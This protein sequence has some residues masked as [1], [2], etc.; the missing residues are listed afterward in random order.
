MTIAFCLSHDDSNRPETG[1]IYLLDSGVC[2]FKRRSYFL[3]ERGQKRK[4]EL[5]EEGEEDEDD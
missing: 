1:N 4:R 5:D 2:V 3:E